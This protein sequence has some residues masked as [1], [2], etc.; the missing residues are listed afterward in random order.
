MISTQPIESAATTG[1]PRRLI[2]ARQVGR[3]LGCSWRHVLRLADTGLLPWGVKLGR[4]RR[5]DLSEID[6]FIASGCKMGLL[7]AAQRG[8]RDAGREGR[9]DGV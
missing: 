8:E 2:D 1:Q 7:R 3:L 5:W 9:A 6:S 4:L